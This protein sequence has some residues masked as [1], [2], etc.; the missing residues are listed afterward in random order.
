MLP[1]IMYSVSKCVDD[2]F[3]AVT[4]YFENSL[5]LKVYPHD[6]LFPSVSIRNCKHYCPL[7]IHISYGPN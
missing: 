4:F 2:G 3:P 7:S 1:C 6:Y 5:S